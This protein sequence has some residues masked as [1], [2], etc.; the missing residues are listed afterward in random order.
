MQCLSQILF[1][2]P[3]A[4]LPKVRRTW[5]LL[6]SSLDRGLS[7]SPSIPFNTNIYSDCDPPPQAEVDS[8][9]SHLFTLFFRNNITVE[10]NAG[11]IIKSGG[12]LKG[13]AVDSKVLARSF[14]QPTP[15]LQRIVTFTRGVRACREE[16]TPHRSGVCHV[17]AL[18]K[19][20]FCSVL[21]I[22]PTIHLKYK[23][24][25]GRETCER[26]RGVRYM[27]H[28]GMTAPIETLRS[29]SSLKLDHA[30]RTLFK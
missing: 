15:D 22:P 14:L 4:V 5:C 2:P 27:K 26:R 19:N 13:F 30:R 23:R 10:I 17:A 1:V 9:A 18:S 20:N 7:R 3:L 21:F 25:E 12:F 8:R 6:S 28:R 24:S 16:E 11:M 29:L